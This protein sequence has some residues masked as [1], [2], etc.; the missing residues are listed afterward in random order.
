MTKLVLVTVNGTGVPAPFDT[1][2]TSFPGWVGA[3]MADPWVPILAQFVGPQWQQDVFWQPIGYPAAVTNMGAS[4]LQGWN[5]PGGITDSL[6]RWPLD[7]NIA[8]FGYSQGAMVVA[9]WWRSAVLNPQGA[10]HARQSAVKV[11][12]QVGDPYRCPGIAHGNELA[13]IPLPAKKDGQITGGIGGPLDLTVEQTPDFYYSF[14]LDGDLYAA[15]P[16]GA[17][18]G[19]VGV[20]KEEASAGYVGAS[21]FNAVQ[22][23]SFLNI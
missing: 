3:A 22:K 20:P 4:V 21:I 17:G 9:E 13:G 16:T 2:P 19:G 10:D 8:L 1:G 18:P 15:C 7:T 5:G 12:F 11:I 14:A 23:T 6:R